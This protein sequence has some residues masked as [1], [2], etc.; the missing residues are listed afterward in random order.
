MAPPTPVE[1]TMNGKIQPDASGGWCGTFPKYEPLLLTEDEPRDDCFG[2]TDKAR[3]GLL[4]VVSCRNNL[5]RRVVHNRLVPV[6]VVAV[7]LAVTEV[8]KEDVVLV[9][10]DDP[11]RRLATTNIVVM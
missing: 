2:G 5:C 9:V 4:C 1:T 6:V 10:N 8:T 3:R 11:K 7:V